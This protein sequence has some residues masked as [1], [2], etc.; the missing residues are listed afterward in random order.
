MVLALSSSGKATTEKIAFEI[1]KRKLYWKKDGDF[2]QPSQ[3]FL[4]ARNYPKILKVI[5]RNTIKIN[6]GKLD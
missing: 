3:I 1:R 4:R 2:P 6:R 5:D